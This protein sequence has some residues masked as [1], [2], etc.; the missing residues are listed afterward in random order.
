[1]MIMI[2]SLFPDVDLNILPKYIESQESFIVVCTVSDTQTTLIA[3]DAD[4]CVF[5]CLPFD[6][7]LCNQT[8]RTFDI[9]CEGDRLIVSVSPAVENDFTTWT[10]SAF[11][12]GSDSEQ[13]Q[14]FGEAFLFGA[15]TYK[16][17]IESFMSSNTS[18]FTMY[19]MKHNML[20]VIKLNV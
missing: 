15:C 1:M 12:V 8:G 17:M 16:V 6:T 2:H 10:C 13:L 7:S 9:N 14:K 11:N 3:R 20:M 5:G 4:T 18:I 19:T